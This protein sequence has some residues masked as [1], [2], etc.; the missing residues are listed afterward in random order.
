[1]QLEVGKIVEGKVSGITKFGAFVDLGEGKTGMVHI[2]EV[3]AA[4]SY[5]HLCALPLIAHNPGGP[6]RLE[7]TR[8]DGPAVQLLRAGSE[9]SQGIALAKEIGRMTGGMDMLAAGTRGR[10]PER[11]CV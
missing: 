11:R 5:T 9:F 7:A 4:V 1:M 10:E 8:P 6:R 2:S 3:A